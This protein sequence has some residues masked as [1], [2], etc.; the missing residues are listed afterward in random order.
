MTDMY[1]SAFIALQC[2]A[3]AG[4]GRL[5][6]KPVP[7]RMHVTDGQADSQRDQPRDQKRR[8]AAA[9]DGDLPSTHTATTMASATSPTMG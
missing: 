5:E 7:H 2:A 9:C 8:N 6:C 1:G 3:R 4:E